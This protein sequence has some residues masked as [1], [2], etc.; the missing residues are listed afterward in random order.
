VKKFDV[1]LLDVKQDQNDE[2]KTVL[3]LVF[4]KFIGSFI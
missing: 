1:R 2:G 4:L 3:N